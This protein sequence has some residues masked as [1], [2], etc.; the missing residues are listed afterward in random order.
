MKTRGMRRAALAAR[1]N[2]RRADAAIT[3]RDAEM[4][5]LDRR[6]ANRKRLSKSGQM[7]LEQNGAGT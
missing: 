2:H 7:L 5:A 4:V 1:A 3:S 6:R